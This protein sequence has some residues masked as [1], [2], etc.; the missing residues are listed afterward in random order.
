MSDKSL[1]LLYLAKG[2]ESSHQQSDRAEQVETLPSAVPRASAQGPGPGAKVRVQPPEH[3]SGFT[4]ATVTCCLTQLSTQAS[5]HIAALPWSNTVGRCGE[6][7]RQVVV[8]VHRH[9]YRNSRLLTRA[10][11]EK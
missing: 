5:C 10:A 3:C 2:S 11:A 9:T 8:L 6:C 1:D 4:R 7:I